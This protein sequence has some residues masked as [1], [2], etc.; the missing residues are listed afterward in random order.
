MF[1]P[2]NG[3]ITVFKEDKTYDQRAEENRK[4]NGYKVPS[5]I[6][7]ASDL[8][9]FQ[10]RMTGTEN[11][12]FE[13]PHCTYREILKHLMYLKKGTMLPNSKAT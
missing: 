2:A 6:T 12:K 11:N 3:K 8:D 4:Q 7:M 9:K 5:R 1:A 13:I 10:W